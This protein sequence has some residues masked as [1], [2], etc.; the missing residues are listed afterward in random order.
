MRLRRRATPA[1]KRPGSGTDGYYDATHAARRDVT[2]FVVRLY[3]PDQWMTDFGHADLFA[4]RSAERLVWR[5][6]LNWILAHRSDR[7]HHE[8]AEARH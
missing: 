6:I 3:D 4:A 2:K 7:E 1:S 5:P 8:L